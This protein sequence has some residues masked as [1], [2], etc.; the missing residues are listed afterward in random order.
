MARVE[1]AH[2]EVQAHLLPVLACLVQIGA[3]LRRFGRYYHRSWHPCSWRPYP[4]RTLS[5]PARPSRGGV[6]E[7]WP[8]PRVPANDDACPHIVVQA[9]GHYF[10]REVGQRHQHKAPLP[11]P[12]VGDL[13]TR[14]I[15]DQ[16]VD[17]QDID[18]E[19]AGAPAHRAGPARQRLGPLSGRQQFER[20]GRGLQFSDHVE[21]GA[22]PRW[23]THRFCFVHAGNGDHA[24]QLSQPG[25][26]I[27][28]AVTEV[29]TEGNENPVPVGIGQV[30]IG[31]VGIGQVG[32][33]QVGIGLAGEWRGHGRTIR[34]AAHVMSTGTGGRNFRTVTTTPS[35]RP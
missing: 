31:Q 27:G 18:V 33:G 4:W 22:L 25:A 12:R 3:P 5:W 9:T 6:E 2:S 28:P 23:A 10:R 8:G 32:I 34:T 14:E 17:E 11:H 24:G 30:G 15:N 19:S 26:Q 13:Q 16:V 35:A 29:G 21:V 20:S 1:R 7:R